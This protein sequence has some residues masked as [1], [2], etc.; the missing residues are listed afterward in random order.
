MEQETYI[1]IKNTVKKILNL[2][3]DHYKDEQMKRRLDSWLVR[4]GA[5]NWD[6][7]FIR[8]RKESKELSRFRDY[9]TINV[10]SFFRDPERW[11]SL[12]DTVIPRLFK[13]ARQRNPQNPTLH[14]W[15]AGCSIGPEPYTLAMILDD[16]SAYNRHEI[17][18]TDFDKGAL[19]KA[20]NRGPYTAE[21]VQNLSAKQKLSYLQSGGP[22]YFVSEKIAKRVQ[23]KEH[24]LLDDPFPQNMDLVVCRN[25]VIYFTGETKDVLYR[26]FRDALR[27]GGILFVGATEIVP[28]PQEI[29]LKGSGISFYEK[30]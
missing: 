29:G 2:N 23:F 12:K 5:S 10:S 15:S 17:L 30:V 21:E 14:I 28:R 25:V 3:L 27:M 1:Y 19:E 8:I 24:N 18:A 26:K 16:V 4:N 22:P 7:Y 6:E 20:K 11:Q 9:L 13:E